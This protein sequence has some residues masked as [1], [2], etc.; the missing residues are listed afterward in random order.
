MQ[1]KRLHLIESVRHPGNRTRLRVDA[2]GDLNEGL[3]NPLS[4]SDRDKVCSFS[5]LLPVENV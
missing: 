1:D 2:V 5:Q 4:V 3:V